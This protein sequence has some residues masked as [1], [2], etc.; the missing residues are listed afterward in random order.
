MNLYDVK[1]E[2]APLAEVLTSGS[3]PDGYA[4]D[5]AECLLA[6]NKVDFGYVCIVIHAHG[7]FAAGPRRAKYLEALRDTTQVHGFTIS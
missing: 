2:C 5:R 6:I 4:G 7:T 1:R 3:V